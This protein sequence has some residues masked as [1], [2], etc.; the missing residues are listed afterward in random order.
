[1]IASV[2]SLSA[3]LLDRV[4]QVRQGLGLE[5]AG[6]ADAAARFSD[7]LDSMGMVEFLALLAED[8]GVTPESLERCVGGHFS[9]VAELARCLHNAGFSPRRAADVVAQPK[10][11]VEHRSVAVRSWLT[12][13]VLRVPDT[14]QPAAAINTALGR[15]IGWLEEHAGIHER[16]I[17]GAQDPLAAAAA[18]GR[19]CLDQ[20]GLLAEEVGVLLATSE[21][22]PLLTGLGAA[23]HHRLE[24]RPS[25]VA[26]EVGGACTGFLA[27]LWLA[28]ELVGRAG[29]VLLVAVEAPTQFLKLEPGPAGEA[30]ALFGDGAAASLLCGRPLGPGCVPLNEV[31][32]TTDGAAAGLLQVERT[33]TGAVGVRMDGPALAA[34]AVRAMADGVS[35]LAK[36]HGLAMTDLAGVVAHGGNGRLPGLLAR[37]LGLPADCVW[38]ETPRLG[39]LGSASLPAA[40]ALG[41]SRARGP[42]VW[43]AVGAGLTVAGAV[44]GLLPEQKFV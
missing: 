37:R 43:T 6:A 27:G 15:P 5:S 24:L 44:L 40:W 16:R 29:A 19:A 34:R 42:V 3:H 12:A 38:S 31:T 20:A 23:L 33:A 7:L 8:C 2:D 32:L 18:A 21:A 26:L 17:W 13:M 1:M 39:N 36:R 28:G 10:P 25:A 9:T 14:V 11:A 41:Q 4:R 35:I 30:A 22:P